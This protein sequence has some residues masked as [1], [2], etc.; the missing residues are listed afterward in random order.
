MQYKLRNDHLN[1]LDGDRARM[2]IGREELKV[3]LKGSEE[4]PAI[5]KKSPKGFGYATDLHVQNFLECVRTR[6]NPHCAHARGISGRAC[7]ADGESVVEKRPALQME[8]G[9]W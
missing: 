7:G 9:C 4:E 5:V 3:F 1:H 8:R 6:K 2:D